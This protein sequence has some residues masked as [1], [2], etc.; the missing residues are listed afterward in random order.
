MLKLQP[1]LPDARGDFLLAE[2]VISCMGCM[3]FNQFHHELESN[4]PYYYHC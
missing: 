3:E 1:Y 4:F 2:L